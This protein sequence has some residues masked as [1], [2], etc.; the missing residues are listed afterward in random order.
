ME[1]DEDNTKFDQMCLDV[2]CIEK[3]G[4]RFFVLVLF[5][6]ALALQFTSKLTNPK[7]KEAQWA[8]AEQE[9]EW[10][11][12]VIKIV[13]KEVVRAD[14]RCV[15]LFVLLAV[16]LKKK[17][18]QT[19]KR[20]GLMMRLVGSFIVPFSSSATSSSTDG[21]KRDSSAPRKNDIAMDASVS[22]STLTENSSSGGSNQMRE[23]LHTKGEGEEEEAARRIK[24]E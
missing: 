23:E 12:E 24:W 21:H 3:N 6:L 1:Y 4:W 9:E 20:D 22:E 16:L 13:A 15:S 11:V 17:E 2:C 14:S 10:R 18:K 7:T 5:F 8:L 19:M